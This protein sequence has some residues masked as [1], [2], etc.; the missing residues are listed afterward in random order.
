MEVVNDIIYF[1]EIGAPVSK[2]VYYKTRHW[3]IWYDVENGSP[4]LPVYRHSANVQRF[5]FPHQYSVL[6]LSFLYNFFVLLIIYCF[7]AIHNRSIIFIFRLY[8]PVEQPHMSVVN[9]ES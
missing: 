2:A 8:A 4:V 7:N 1:I 6:K 9:S 5:C 3:T